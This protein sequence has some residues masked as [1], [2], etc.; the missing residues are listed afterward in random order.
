[1][2]AI[3]SEEERRALDAVARD[4]LR[5]LTGLEFRTATTPEEVDATFRLRYEAVVANGWARPDDHP[6][7]RERDADDPHAVSVVCLDGGRVVGCLRLVKPSPGRLLPAERDFDLR[8]EPEGGVVDAGRVV[9]APSHRGALSHLV[10]TGL[11][12]R[13]WLEARA[14]G[15][16]RVVGVASPQAIALYEGLGMRVAV[17]GPPRPYWGED[18]QPIEI[19]G[20]SESA[21]AQYGAPAVVEGVA[22]GDDDEEGLSRRDLLVR[23]GGLSA[24]A[25][26]LVG[27]PQAAAA[28][29]SGVGAGPTDRRTIEFV[30]QIDQVGAGL[31]GHGYLTHVKG[32]SDSLLF[33]RPLPTSG[34]DPSS[35]DVEA[36]RFVLVLQAA[37]GS[38]TAIGS[39]IA[40]HGKGTAE[41]RLLPSGGARLDDPASFGGTSVATFALEFQHNLAIDAPDRALAS[42]TADLTQKSARAFELQGRSYQL[43]K[44]AL[45]WSV[46]ASGRGVRTDPETPTSQHFVSGDMGVVDAVNRR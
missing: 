43:G 32:L 5:T 12:A 37:I 7:A 18:R 8:L 33:T 17:L 25:L 6:D 21:V 16:E 13:G 46:R 29:P 22:A 19:L 35:D 24:G 3:A 40:G 28:T 4:V 15:F 2:L 10:L 39:A 30:C 9:V 45:P 34:A 31:A 38:I 26:V 23:V 41:F 11:V 14:L 27:V 36:A 1:M 20:A 44:A 42:F